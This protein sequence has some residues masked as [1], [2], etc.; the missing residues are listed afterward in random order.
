MSPSMTRRQPAGSGGA[1][2]TTF[3][4]SRLFHLLAPPIRAAREGTLRACVVDRSEWLT[5]AVR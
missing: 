4:F 3:A 1:Y 2:S 5:N